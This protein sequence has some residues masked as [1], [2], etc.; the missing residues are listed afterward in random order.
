LKLAET[1]TPL[2]VHVRLMGPSGRGQ[3]TV[4]APW[5]TPQCARREDDGEHRGHSQREECPHEEEGFAGL[6]D[7]AT[8][9]ASGSLHVDDRDDQPQERPEE[10]DDVTGSPFGERQRSVQPD[11]ENEHREEIHEPWPGHLEEDVVG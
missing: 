6:A 11:D 1:L 4:A 7:L 2:I 8:D 9:K 10:N 5:Q 3:T